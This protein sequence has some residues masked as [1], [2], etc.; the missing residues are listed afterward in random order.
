MAENQDG[1]ERSEQPT[2]KRL[3][4]AKKKGQVP[5]SKELNTFLSLLFGALGL[6]VLGES[7][8]KNIYVQAQQILGLGIG[9]DILSVNPA[10]VL[11]AAILDAVWFLAPFMGLMLLGVFAGPL[12]MGGWVFSPELIAFKLEKLDPLKGLQRIFSAKGLIE[13]VKAIAKF[14]VMTAAAYGVFMLVFDQLMVLGQA[15]PLAAIVGSTEILLLGMTVLSLAMISIV[16]VDVPFQLW[17][18]TKQMR[19]TLQEVKDE[20]KETDGRP[21]VKGRIRQLQREMSTRRM[22][23]EVPTA[24]VVITNPTHYAVALKYDRLSGAAPKVVAKGADEIAARIREI[25][26]EHDVM[27]FSAPPLARAL[28]NHVE[29][30]QSIPEKLYLAV[31]RVLAYVYHITESGGLGDIERPDDLYIP[32]EYRDDL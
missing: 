17:D 18:F 12:L 13:L 20:M 8:A 3:L 2:A 31:A 11:G 30:D 28:F 27:I 1:Q 25:A 23:E 6:M 22:M 29:L 7:L 4:D 9:G 10:D 19:M 32:E 14:L 16:F 21:E 24:D 5:R 15:Q 26:A